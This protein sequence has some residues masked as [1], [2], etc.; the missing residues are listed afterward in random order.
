MK[1]K[2]FHPEPSAREQA[3]PRYWKSPDE[4]S[5]T[6][7]F[8]EWL[9]QEFPEGASIAEETDRRAFLKL[10]GASFAL[11]GVGLAGC[12]MPEQK[13]LPYSKQPERII[14]G[15][16]LYYASS[17]PRPTDHL[18]LIVETHEARPTKIEGNPSDPATAGA[19][20]A[21]AQSSV[22]DLY[23]PDRLQHARRK[24]G[25]RVSKAAVRD[26][27]NA[28][29]RAFADKG[30]KGLAFLASSSSSPSR[31]RAVAALKEAFPE[32]IWAE[33]EAVDWTAPER[34]CKRAT[35]KRLRS[36]YQLKSAKRVVAL[37]AD[38]LATEPGHLQ[39]ARAFAAGRRVLHA[40]E[41][42]NM[43]RLYA[44]ESRF[45]LTGAMADH[46][47][48]AATSHL[49]AFTALLAAEVI[50][51]TGGPADL[52]ATL[53]S[54]AA[55]VRVD[56]QWL[57]ECARDL[58]E[59]RG[60][61]VVIPGAHLPEEV[62]ILALY[63]NS[64]L[65]AED[66]LV[67]YRQLPEHDAADIV[68]LADAMRGG[69]VE[70]LYILGGNPAYD[71]PS[72]L[73]WPSLQQRVEEVVKVGYYHDETAEL[74]DLCIA[75]NHYLEC[76][77]DGRT[78]DGTYVPVQPM[79]LPLFE[80]FNELEIIA[81]LAGKSSGDSEGYDFVR[82]TFATLA[83]A[84]GERGFAFEAWLAEGLLPG[85]AYA[86]TSLPDLSGTLP[87]L[88]GDAPAAVAPGPR[89]LEVRI[90][91]ST[92]AYDGRYNNNGWQMEAP[93]PMSKLTWDNAIL[94]SPKMARELDIVP[95]PILMDRLGQLH[96]KAQTFEGGKEQAPMARLTVNGRTI[97]G[98]LHVQPGLA[99]Y[100]VVLSLG[101]GRR[102]TGRVG[103]RLYG[104]RRGEGIGFDAYPL[105]LSTATSL[106]TGATLE[107]TGERFELANVQEHWSMEGRA[108]IREANVAEYQANPDFTTQMGMEAHSPP[109]LGAA[110]KDPLQDVVRN[111]PRG[112]SA[113]ETPPFKAPQQWGMSIDLN[114]CIGC[115]ACVVAC[116]SENN[117]P[118]V[119]K[120]QVLRGREMH[121]IRLDR[122]YSSGENISANPQA[123]MEIP[124]DPQVSFM[125]VACMHCELA[126]CESVCPVNATVHD[127]QGLN[128]MAYNRCVGT[129]YCANNCP[130]KVRRFNFFDYNK[131]ERGEVYKG[132]FGEKRDQTTLQMQRNPDVT[133]RMRGVMEKCTYCVQRIE[134][135]KINQKAQARDSANILVPD[136]TIKTAC[137]Q[138]CPTGAIVFGDLADAHTAVSRT[139]ESDRDYALLGYL[140]VRPRTTFLAKLRNPN[141]RMPDYRK[142]PLS[143]LEY[144]QKFGHG[145][146]VHGI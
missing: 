5:G 89:Q 100:T 77:S 85:S 105:V 132:P 67:E 113:Y 66:G 70:T 30:G 83:A 109:I 26:A 43:N 146:A 95:K 135:A 130:Y 27:L 128:V 41:A 91:P 134:A 142:Q 79:I 54:R 138:V 76:W 20:D 129:R 131:R 46:R 52:A 15:V 7:E 88:L 32:A 61:A 6:P 38:F 84:G 31:Q 13:I 74:A 55:G 68:A 136:G 92:H 42:G 63:I 137:Q 120:D 102:R 96:M 115:N 82:E 72:D 48:R 123:A 124:E 47:L 143:R 1:R 59:N 37:D 112:G 22:L 62:H 49:P 24:N 145:E 11:A 80:G 12:R 35:G 4:L 118:I 9:E 60:A 107:L 3:G 106:R 81:M 108:I 101:F 51:L 144:E 34:A 117:I 94:V 99:D 36:V 140:N 75:Q 2:N 90:V 10:M 65:G 121:W 73:D 111:I 86:V 64:L 45:T 93:D 40:A 119:G 25:G 23:D 127:D 78:W 69:E 126:P 103:T 56:E 133:V 16:P 44:V 114:T 21:F 50:A 19:T 141:P 18:P 53:K 87:A 71:A 39:Y 28:T 33:Y 98:P 104:P 17:Q 14:P 139:K 122:Y 57:R 116:Q 125:G 8:K 58:V 110:R 29:R 97:E